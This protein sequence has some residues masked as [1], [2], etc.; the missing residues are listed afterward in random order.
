MAA[1]TIPDAAAPS[2]IR[3]LKRPMPRRT[4]RPASSRD[5]P[6]SRLSQTSASTASGTTIPAT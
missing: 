5:D 6:Q 3:L 4:R 2:G 1:S